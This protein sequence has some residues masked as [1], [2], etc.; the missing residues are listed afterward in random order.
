MPSTRFFNDTLAPIFA[1][2]E[3]ACA[4]CGREVG[5][6]KDLR[7]RIR[8]LE[9]E[10]EEDEEEEEDEEAEEDEGGGC[11]REGGGGRGGG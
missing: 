3:D 1:R 6:C 2:L 9:A 7:G 8:M 10:D 11:A 4:G 5:W